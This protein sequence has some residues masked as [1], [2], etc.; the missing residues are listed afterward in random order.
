MKKLTLNEARQAIKADET[1][2]ARLLR[3]PCGDVGF[4][5]PRPTDPQ[6]PHKRDEL[7]II[8]SGRGTFTCRGERT[9]FQPGDALYVQRG[10]E[11]RFDTFSEDFAAWVIFFGPAP[12][13]QV[14]E[15]VLSDS[16]CA[17]GEGRPSG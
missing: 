11:H 2:Y 16:L 1:I 3:E 6:E 13:R 9:S 17:S 5:R 10:T 4:Y 14:A 12:E 8:A 7:Y 15:Q